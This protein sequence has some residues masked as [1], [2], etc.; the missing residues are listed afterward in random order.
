MKNFFKKLERFLIEGLIFII[1][2]TITIWVFYY[3]FKLFYGFFHFGIYF[4]PIEIRQLPFVKIGVTILVFLLVLLFLIIIG[5][6]M[7]SFFGKIINSLFDKL[8]SI[9]PIFKTFYT[10]LKQLS[11]LIFK[12]KK[13]E[14]SSVVLVE[15]PIKG[16]YSIGFITS[17]I[18]KSIISEDGKEY[19]SVFVPT[20]PNP[21]S[22]FTILVE[23]E[24]VKKIDMS[25][26]EAIKFVVFVGSL[27]ENG[28]KK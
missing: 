18:D 4:I 22:G 24:K 26:E 6:V 15:F 11:S 28:D 20:S 7:N 16:N 12:E 3:F 9:I 14:F 13:T 19:Y 23:K 5:M 25:V 27:K 10:S 2:I 8:F 17:K 1:P 21:T